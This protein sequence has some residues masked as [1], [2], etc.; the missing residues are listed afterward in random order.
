[1]ATFV[2]EE[3]L[4]FVRSLGRSST[5]L[6]S[7]KPESVPFRAS[8]LGRQAARCSSG[9]VSGYLAHIT[10]LK[11]VRSVRHPYIGNT[12]RALRVPLPSG[13]LEEVDS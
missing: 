7:P 12:E 1:M 9:L 11:N 10:C 8:K 5:G 2:D 3:A 13:R 6:A 4:G